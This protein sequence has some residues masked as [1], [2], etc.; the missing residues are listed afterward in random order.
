MGGLYSSESV[1]PND[2]PPGINYVLCFGLKSRN[3][4]WEPSEMSS[5]CLLE[6]MEFSAHGMG[7]L[8]LEDCP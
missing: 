2:V 8:M 3:A 4:S 5:S 7:R 6:S 1:F